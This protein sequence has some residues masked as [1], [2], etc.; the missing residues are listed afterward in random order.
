[1]TTL[2]MTLF[3]A[4]GD[5]E[6]DTAIEDVAEETTEEEAEDTATSEEE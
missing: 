6:E 1:M 3:F 2:L 4:C 5:K